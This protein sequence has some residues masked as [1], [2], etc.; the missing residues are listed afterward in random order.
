MSIFVAAQRAYKV[1]DSD[2]VATALDV[3]QESDWYS[4]CCRD[5]TERI[6]WG[7]KVATTDLDVRARLIPAQSLFSLF[8]LKIIT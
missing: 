1:E 5:E 6:K 8:Y 2:G 3:W 7:I 4:G